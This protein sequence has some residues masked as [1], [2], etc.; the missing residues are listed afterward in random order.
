MDT[1]ECYDVTKNT[2][3]SI[4]NANKKRYAASATGMS[5]LDKILLFGGRSDAHNLMTEEI[6]EYDVN[7]N[8]WAI[9]KLKQPCE[10]IPVEV[11]AS[12]QI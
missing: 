11:C 7:K 8:T 4:A 3:T 2:W 10:W 12:I 6:E 5:E 9:L 1:C